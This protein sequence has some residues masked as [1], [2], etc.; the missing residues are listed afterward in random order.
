[1]LRVVGKS[2]LNLK[3]VMS[4]IVAVVGGEYGGH[5]HAAG[6][7]IPTDKEGEFIKAAK[8]VLGKSAMEEVIV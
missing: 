6:A 7:I 3:S 1:S 2:E 4:K 5:T 8:T